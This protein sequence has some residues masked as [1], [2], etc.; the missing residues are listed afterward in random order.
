MS[1]QDKL[2]NH[3]KQRAFKTFL[4]VEAWC[5]A[6]LLISIITYYHGKLLIS[7][8]TFQMVVDVL[9]QTSFQRNS[10]QSC[11]YTAY[12]VYQQS[13]LTRL[14]VYAHIRHCVSHASLGNLLRETFLLAYCIQV[15]KSDN[16][17]TLFLTVMPLPRLI[18]WLLELSYTKFFA[19]LL[20]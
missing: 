6:E 18:S 8:I 12:I 4:A 14:H 10:E 16:G 11:I 20:D 2:M 15:N 9:S 5:L 7:Q 13:S 1:R 17:N 3:I 19:T